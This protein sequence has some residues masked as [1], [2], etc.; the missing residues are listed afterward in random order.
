VKTKPIEAKLN[1]ICRL[2]SLP[3]SLNVI[4]VSGQTASAAKKRLICGLLALT[5]KDKLNRILL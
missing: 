1:R 4:T 3:A 2:L 5:C